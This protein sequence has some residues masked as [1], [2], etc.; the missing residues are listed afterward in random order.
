MA[1]ARSRMICL[2]LVNPY[3]FPLPCGGGSTEIINTLVC[4]LLQ[5]LHYILKWNYFDNCLGFV[6]II[7]MPDEESFSE[8]TVGCTASQFI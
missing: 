6:K 8:T 5:L 4:S 1:V 3:L 2:G 7:G